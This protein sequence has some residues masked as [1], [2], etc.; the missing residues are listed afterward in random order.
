MMIHAMM[1]TTAIPRTILEATL[2][3]NLLAL[4]LFSLS[5]LL[6]V[7]FPFS[8]TLSV[9]SSYLVAEGRADLTM[10]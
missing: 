7:R 3:T 5:V 2:D 6:V 1:V 8:M 9:S 4:F 10:P